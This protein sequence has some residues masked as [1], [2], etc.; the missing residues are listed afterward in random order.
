MLNPL[1]VQESGGEKLDTKDQST[2]NKEA[3]VKLA[4]HTKGCLE[5]RKLES[6][7]GES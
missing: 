7:G 3:P 2:K 6:V 5:K 4:M 1:Q